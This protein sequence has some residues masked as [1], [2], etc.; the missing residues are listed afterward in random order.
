[1]KY[2][3]LIFLALFELGSLLCAV[4]P[5]SAVFIVGRAVSGAGGAGILNGCLNVL[6]VTAPLERRPML[7]G[8]AMS[9]STIGTAA[10][11]LVGGALTDK[12]TWRWCKTPHPAHEIK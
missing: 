7:I 11:P 6:T 4:S 2:T 5:N 8:A 3:F 9:I 1:M 10:G 12:L